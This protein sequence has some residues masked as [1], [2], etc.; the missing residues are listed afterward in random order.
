VLAYAR[1]GHT[2]YVYTGDLDADRPTS[3]TEPP[4]TTSRSVPVYESD[5]ETV[6]GE[7]VIEPGIAGPGTLG[8]V[9]P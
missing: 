5:G 6:I 3:L 9:A 1:N 7:F 4:V 2:G 8:S